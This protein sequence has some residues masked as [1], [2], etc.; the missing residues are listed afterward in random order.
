MANTLCIIL[1]TY[2]QYSDFYLFVS[3]LFEIWKI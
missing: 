1:T 2:M 3:S